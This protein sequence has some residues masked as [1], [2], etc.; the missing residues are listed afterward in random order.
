MQNVTSHH[1]RAVVLIPVHLGADILI[2]STSGGIR[3][4][5]RIGT[6]DRALPADWFDDSM[7]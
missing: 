1:R 7:F 6:P 4:T 2:C 3:R 5:R